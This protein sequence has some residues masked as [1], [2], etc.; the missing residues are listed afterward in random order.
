MREARAALMAVMFLTR[1]PVPSLADFRDEDLQ[2]AARWFPAVGALVG[3]AQA[4]VLVIAALV[5]PPLAAALLALAAAL[6]MTGAF[7]EDGLA[8]AVDGLGGGYTR[9][10]VL[11]IMKDSRIGSFGAAALVIALA[12]QA[13]ALAE[14]VAVPAAIIAVHAA[15]RFVALS[16][17]ATQDYVR[18]DDSAR[19]KPMAT[20]IGWRGLAFAAIPVLVPALFLPWRAVL[21]GAM[22]MI[23]ARLYWGWVCQ[24]RL[25]GYTG[26]MLGAAQQISFTAGL[27][28]VVAAL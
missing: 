18:D 9:E 19:A 24:R 7:H 12:L 20:R 1:I 27:L 16:V 15:S 17:M 6:L 22:A 21:A 26:D 25:G 3:A 4:L 23:L 28:G 10:R 5:L 14:L 8:D 2:G 11:T 13:V